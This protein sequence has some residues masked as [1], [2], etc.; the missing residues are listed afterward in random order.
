[1]IIY[2]SDIDRKKMPSLLL[3]S[4]MK[5]VTMKKKLKWKWKMLEHSNKMSNK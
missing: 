2:A 4:L 1:L 3:L 5:K